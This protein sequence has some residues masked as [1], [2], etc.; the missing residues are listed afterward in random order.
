MHR[1]GDSVGDQHRAVAKQLG[2]HRAGA[3][4]DDPVQ[5]LGEAAVGVADL[6]AE[7]GLASVSIGMPRHRLT[8]TVPAA[9]LRLPSKATGVDRPAAGAAAARSGPADA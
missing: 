6:G 9:F 1:A 8:A 3:V 5:G 7:L 4:A 2:L